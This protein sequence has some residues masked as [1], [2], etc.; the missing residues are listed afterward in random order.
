MTVRF[1]PGITE[2]RLGRRELSNRVVH[3]RAELASLAG[4]LDGQ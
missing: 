3:A 4:T 1:E 2:M